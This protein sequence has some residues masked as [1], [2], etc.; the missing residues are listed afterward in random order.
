MG[1]YLTSKQ[2]KILKRSSVKET[3]SNYSAAVD[4]NSWIGDIDKVGLGNVGDVVVK[5]A[6]YIS[7]FL[8]GK[9]TIP[10]MQSNCTLT[11]TQWVNPNNPISRAETIIKEG[12][13]YG[14]IEIPES[15]LRVGDLVI[16][17]N[18]N[19]NAHH[20]M[21]VSG[22]TN[23]QQKHNFYN[24]EYL[25]PKG[26][27]LVRYSTGTT[28]PSG[29][30]KAIGLLEYTDNSD[31]KTNLKYYR[32]YNPGQKE[33]LLPTVIV[34]PKKNYISG[35]KRSIIINQNEEGLFK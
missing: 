26:H 29:Y 16:A 10:T 1:D 23:S 2:K 3:A 21:L 35:T 7:N 30:R 5:N 22:F 9:K 24:K 15:H 6:D 14:Y 27:P 19:S 12:N 18:P 34:T 8:F 13:K 25:L 11:A 20:T 33:V 28:H 32:H 31:G 17:T 4:Q